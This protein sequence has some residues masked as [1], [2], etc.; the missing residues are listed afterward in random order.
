MV[1][2][3][4]KVQTLLVIEGKDITGVGFVIIKQGPAMGFCQKKNLCNGVFH[5]YKKKGGNLNCS[6]RLEPGG[7]D[8]KCDRWLNRLDRLIRS[9]FQNSVNKYNEIK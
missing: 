5:T 9:S 7:I 2:K 3:V 1:S 4:C 6:V 8:W